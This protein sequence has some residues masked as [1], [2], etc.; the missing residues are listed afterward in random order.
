MTVR[1][2]RH[3]AVVEELA[4]WW[5]D[6]R[7][8]GIGSRVVL[9][10]VPPGWGG[11]AVLEDF[12][13][14]V[15]NP[16]GPVTI[17]V[18]IDDVPLV[19]RAVEAGTLRDALRAPFA[20]SK[21]ADLLD[22]DKAAGRVQL[23]LGIGGV[24][25]PALPAA[26]GLLVGSLAV[27]AAGNA[28]DAS[29]AGERGGLARAARALT[30]VSVAAPVAVII[31]EADRLDLGLAVT[32]IENLASRPDGRVL[33][34]AVVAP[35][36][37]LA[38]GLGSADRYGLLGRVRA[39]EANPG[40][41]YGERA[42]LARELCPWLAEA[43][44][45]RIAGRTGTFAEVFAVASADR[46]ADLAG[47]STP[48]GLATVDTVINACM[49]R[50]E[51]SA[52]A[53][54]LGWAGGAL[55][56]RQADRAVQ[57]LGGQ[58]QQDNG[59][60]VRSGGLAR[61]RDPDSAR[62]AEQVAALGDQTR[63]RLAAVVLQEAAGIARDADATLTERTVA[64][65]AAHW[66]RADMDQRDGL[67]EVQCLL[68]RGLERLGDLDAAREVAAAALA[69]LPADALAGKPGRDLLTAALRV[70]S[71]RPGMHDDPMILYAV[72]LAQAN[73]PLLRP[74][75]RVWAAVHLL[76]LPSRREA[77]VTLT[78]QVIAELAD[79]PGRDAIVNQWRMLLA[80]HA[81]R[82][83]YPAASHRLLAPIISSGTTDQQEAAQAVLRAIGGPRADTRLQ[84]IILEAELAATIAGADD[85]LLRLHRTL[86]IS[87]YAL[88]EYLIALRHGTNWVHL[89]VRLLGPDHPQ[90]LEARHMIAA[91]TAQ[92][93][94]HAGALGLF[95]EL[96]PDQV[97]VLGAD[98]PDVLTTRANTAFCT[99]QCGDRAGALGLFRELLPDQVQVL[100]ADHPDVL[101]TRANTAFWAG[102]CG[103]RA[104]ALGLFRELLPDRVQVL[105]ADHPD[106]LGTRADIASWAGQCGDRAGALGLFRE[107]LPDQVRVRGAD[108]PDVLTTRNNIAF[109]TGQCGDRTEALR[110]ARELLPDRVRVLGA[111]H[112]DVLAT[113]AD[114]ASWTGHCGDHAG[115]LRLA[116]ELLP[117]QVR[118][119]GADHPD[120]LATRANTAFWASE[121][122]DR[123]GALGLFRELLPDQVRVLGAD[124]P[125]VLATRSNIAFWMGECGDRAGALGL[126]RELLPDQVWVRGADH[127]DVLATRA[128]IAFWTDQGGG[129]P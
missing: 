114:I 105:G 32:M 40:M 24:F 121:C 50:E 124:H 7:D 34:A 12:A 69:E 102:Q 19:S 113:R 11:S 48:S 92:C 62:V 74:E 58:P 57:V 80:F 22:L 63:R 9:V 88:G 39:A 95:R 33:V 43:A 56:V 100:G 20:R 54:V 14:L 91:W 61:L 82:A 81:G 94:D 109:W 111:D 128:D 31:D 93:G 125:D 44:I 70:A 42:E 36:S 67:A 53:R 77:A 122:G 76:N 5:E 59:W 17:L 72:T 129:Q 52:Q 47:D 10:Q 99:G 26:V 8:G 18:R 13:G 108:H 16:A 71:T 104:G 38:D 49:V 98:H 37:A 85:D 103:D 118:V 101:A 110:L 119:L 46:L 89:S 60:V 1:S 90:A 3:R 127:P 96:L 117:D 64:R 75:A 23:G 79:L 106:V 51:V 97:Q 73:G 78:D 68:I 65:L 84:I 25:A 35:D 21:V 112:P 115:A 83:G 6:V 30:A 126:F 120:V 29:P 27:T 107:L 45:E 55:T 66:V 116:R 87:Y 28:W 41:G 123:A 2:S 4:E 86:A 15:E